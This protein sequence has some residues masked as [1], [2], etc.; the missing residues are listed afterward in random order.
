MKKDKE[1]TP[2]K[3]T[4]EKDT[5]VGEIVKVDFAMQE[6]MEEAGMEAKTYGIWGVIWKLFRRFEREKQQVKKETYIWLLI[7]TGWM[8]GHRFYARR[9][10]LGALYLIFCWTFIPVMMA[11]IDLMEVV[12]IKKDE[13]GYIMM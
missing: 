13:N 11:F 3:E 8:G 7:L 6:A 4:E 10:Y 5:I 12:P 9:Y 2:K 1:G